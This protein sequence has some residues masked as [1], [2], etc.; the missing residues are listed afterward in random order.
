[1]KKSLVSMLILFFVGLQ[2]V[3]AQGREI[4]GV[5]TSAEDGLSIPGVSVIVKGT[6]IGTTTNFDG[7]YSLNVPEG[8]SVLVFSFVGMTTQEVA[9]SGATLNVVME[10]ESIGVD[11][12]MVVAYGVTKKSSFTGSASTVNSDKLK[13]T[14]VTSFEKALSGNVP[15]LQVSSVSGQPGASTEI[16]IRGIGSFSADQNPLYVIDGVPVTTSS[17]GITYSGEEGSTT[18]PLS[19]IN[20]ADI[21][22][23]TVLKD[24]AAASLYGSRAAN[25]V[26][27]ITTKQGKSGKTRFNFSTSHGVT[28]LAMDNFETVSG[29]DFI[30][31]QREGLMNNAIDLQGLSGD[32]ATA[33]VD[34]VMNNY[35][36]TPADGNFTNWDDELM[37]KGQVHNYELSASGGNEKTTFFASVSANQ[38][39]GVARNSDMERITGRVNLKHKATDKLTFTTNLSFGSVKQNIALGGFYYANPFFASRQLLLPTDLVRNPDGSL[40]EESTFGYYNMVREYSLNERS[41]DTWRNTI[42]SSVEY[43][44]LEGLTFKSTFSYDWI[45]TDNLVY[46]SPVSRAGRANKGEVWQR[47]VKNKILTSSNI[48][49]YDKTFNEKHHINVLAG[50]EVEEENS[51]A[52]EAEGYNVPEGIKVNDGAAK[53]NAVGGWDD[54]NTLISYLGKVDYDFMNK[55][56]VSASIRRDGSSKLGADERWANFWSV[57]GSWRLSQEDFISSATWLDDLKVRA[58][59]GTNGTLPVSWYGHKALY[60]VNAYNSQ[61][62]LD[63]SQIA[64]PSLSWEESKNFNAGFDFRVLGRFSG[65]FEYFQ[66]KTESMLMQVPLSRVTGFSSMWQNIGEMENKGWEF[67]LNANVLRDSELK[68]D[69]SFNVSHYKNEITK[70]SNGEPIFDFPYIRKEGEAYNTF[71][72]RDWAG[73]DPDDGAAQW[74]VIDEDGNRAKDDSGNHIKTK[75]PAQ[76]AKAIVGCADPDFTGGINNSLSYKGLSLDFLFNFSIGGDIYNHAAY[77]MM[78]DGNAP[79]ANMMENQL[80]RWQKPGDKARNPKRY[81]NSDT[82]SNWNSSRRI[83]DNDYLRLKS[84]TLGYSLPSE[85]VNKVSLSN[86]KFY[87]TGTNLLTFSSQDEVDV[88]QP[89][90]GS[91]TWEIPTTKTYTFGVNIGF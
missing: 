75:N 51:W 63:Y 76:A 10:S 55:Y 87:F 34:G 48:L 12:V 26:I 70:L 15:G 90:H 43:K 30:M 42:N 4:S 8:E 77:N 14:P 3:L 45:N 53:P 56:Y 20:P 78:G 54:T 62:A 13:D 32:A 5:V 27:V 39:D 18:T 11:E 64:N 9:V 37:R 46:S 59:Y 23:V 21:E 44:I 88:E 47:S 25:G 74:Y 60:S 28:D 72:L 67:T 71:Y 85:W 89:V 24:A 35:Y 83:M 49:T 31:L 73:V 7:Q 91:T 68:W 16:R 69:V 84:L 6:T 57:S 40:T 29:E 52:M 50:Y 81:W 66:K 82:R 61:P 58:S 33:Y 36:P 1:M 22:S 41:S 19:T 38:T 80:D 2:G 17:T 79:T 65:S 86:V